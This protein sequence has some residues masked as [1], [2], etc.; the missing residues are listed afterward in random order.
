ML[1]KAK[2]GKVAY[3]KRITW[4]YFSSLPLLLLAASAAAFPYLD[5]ERFYIYP[6][7]DV[8]LA[9]FIL[10]SW[11]V[12]MCTLYF[13]CV[14]DYNAGI[15][16]ADVVV[17]R[18]G[19]PGTGK[20]STQAYECIEIANRL[21]LDLIEKYKIYRGQVARWRAAND[22]KMLTRWE[23]ARYAY[24]YYI[25]NIDTHIPCLW[26]TIPIEVDG[27]LSYHLSI[28]HFLQR[29]R[30]PG[31]SVLNHDDSGAS[32]PAELSGTGS[33][34]P[35]LNRFFR[36]IRHF[37]FMLRINDQRVT[38]FVIGG[39]SV[40]SKNIEMTGRHK[41]CKPLLLIWL[42]SLLRPLILKLPNDMPETYPR[43]TRFMA[44]LNNL[45]YHI[46]FFR[47]TGEETVGTESERKAATKKISFILPA[48]LNC[49][50]DD[51]AFMKCYEAPRK[52]EPPEYDTSLFVDPAAYTADNSL[53]ANLYE[54]KQKTSE[55]RPSRE[56][57]RAEKER[58]SYIAHNSKQ[59]T[60]EKTATK[61]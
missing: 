37:G 8:F 26:S 49:E 40:V 2:L 41:V 34:P 53:V 6:I 21:W 13:E 45:I 17:M 32:L 43:F 25:K 19:G 30:L 24:K 22:I 18:S 55:P 52:V 50:Y 9:L 12:F 16:L 44:G 7:F 20:T 14:A 33:I 10:T 54:K 48:G 3:E 27:R 23:E 28:N 38:N 57:R 11:R 46:G 31:F 15:N 56:E 59:Q 60:A 58:R 42:H 51:R 4:L 1:N 29:S 5:A 39:R 61:N 47:Y 36:Y 35:E